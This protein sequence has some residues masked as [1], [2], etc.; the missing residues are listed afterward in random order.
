MKLLNDTQI[1]RKTRESGV[2]EVINLKPGTHEISFEHKNYLPQ[3]LPLSIVFH[4]RTNLV[5]EMES[6]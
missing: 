3:S 4:Q 5:V 6:K 2:F 1:R